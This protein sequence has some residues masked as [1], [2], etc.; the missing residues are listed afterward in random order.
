MPYT[1][2]A[3]LR[4]KWSNWRRKE[5]KECVKVFHLNLF[6]FVKLI[7]EWWKLFKM[8]FIRFYAGS[9][10]RAFGC[11]NLSRSW[12]NFQFK[13]FF[14]DFSDSTWI[15]N[16]TSFPG[17]SRWN[18]FRLQS[19]STQHESLQLETQH[20]ITQTRKILQISVVASFNCPRLY[21]CPHV[22][23]QSPP[24]RDRKSFGTKMNLFSKNNSVSF[25]IFR[26]A[27]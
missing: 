21:D 12:Y 1:L 14:T 15:K 22:S 26:A 23:H 10:I 3:N 9:K 20:L 19:S 25:Y 6:L 8:R 18:T 27:S 11:R 16:L 4:V 17:P 13:T 7:P 24:S 5:K 2:N